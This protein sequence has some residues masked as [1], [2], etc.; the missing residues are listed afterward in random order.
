MKHS[1]AHPSIYQFSAKRNNA[2]STALRMPQR[3]ADLGDASC[4]D[5]IASLHQGLWQ[6]V[7]SLKQSDSVSV[8]G[9]PSRCSGNCVSN[10]CRNPLFPM[11]RIVDVRAVMEKTTPTHDLRNIATSVD[12]R[13]KN[14][15]AQG[16]RMQGLMGVSMQGMAELRLK[17]RG[18]AQDMET[19]RKGKTS[20]VRILQSPLSSILRAMSPRAP[21]WKGKQLRIIILVDLGVKSV[22]CKLRK[23]L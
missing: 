7:T 3:L 21:S 18:R 19:Q 5:N 17:G 6:W 2:F 1:H 9:V 4:W 16:R 10:P 11:A 8:L 14:T 23:S 20:P 22:T 13:R 15:G 12:I